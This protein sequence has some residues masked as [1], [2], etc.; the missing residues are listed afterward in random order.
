MRNFK[1]FFKWFF[2]CF[3]KR[4]FSLLNWHPALPVSHFQASIWALN[5]RRCHAHKP[6]RKAVLG[7]CNVWEFYWHGLERGYLIPSTLTQQFQ[8]Y[9]GL[10]V[11]PSPDK[12]NDICFTQH[13]AKRFS[14][15][16]LYL[17]SGID[18]LQRRLGETRCNFEHRWCIESGG[19]GW[20]I[21][22]QTW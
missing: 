18:T 17:F 7:C 20:F 21:A 8:R 5:K 16:S 1:W 3:F 4:F 13:F 10:F 14:L 19:Y 15:F 9:G 2:K 6:D 22:A 12:G 11:I